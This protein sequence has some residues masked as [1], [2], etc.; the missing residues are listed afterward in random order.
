MVSYIVIFGHTVYDEGE[1]IDLSLITVIS[2]ARQLPNKLFQF[3]A[4]TESKYNA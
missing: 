4:S 2:L 3:V 1:F